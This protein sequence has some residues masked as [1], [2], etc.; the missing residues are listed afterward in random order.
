MRHRNTSPNLDRIAAEGVRFENCYASDAPCLP[1]RA[2]LYTGR[3]GYPQRA[4]STTAASAAD[5]FLEG[6]DRGFRDQYGSHRV[7][8]SCARR[9]YARVSVSPFGERHSAWW[10][11]A[12]WREVYNTGFGGM[13]VADDVTPAGGRVDRAQR[14]VRRLVPARQLLGPPHA[15]PHPG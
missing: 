11:Y 4:R 12:G 14:R 1:S 3:F 15:L 5:P 7:D 8:R 13:E 10:W 2:A 9:G 6:S